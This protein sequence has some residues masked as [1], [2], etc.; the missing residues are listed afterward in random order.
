MGKVSR[1]MGGIPR[2][3]KVKVDKERKTPLTL[4]EAC[5]FGDI[6]AVQ[7]FLSQTESSKEDRDIDAQDHRGITCL[8]YA[9]GAQRMGIVTALVESG[10]DPAKVD[11]AGNSGLHYAAAYARREMLDY[12]LNLGLDINARNHSGLTPLG[13]ASRNK[14]PKIVQQL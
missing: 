14:Q 9:I 10:A 3:A 1:R 4:Q 8:G 11:N 13:C 12:L 7:S 6:R 5:K 2:D